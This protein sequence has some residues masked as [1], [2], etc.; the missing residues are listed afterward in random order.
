MMLGPGE[1]TVN[2]AAYVRVM[3]SLSDGGAMT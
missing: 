2:R 3:L 1:W